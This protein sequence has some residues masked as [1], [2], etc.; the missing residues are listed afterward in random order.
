MKR[1]D[2]SIKLLTRFKAMNF[3][4]RLVTQDKTWIQHFEPESKIQSKQRKYW[5]STPEEIQA[6]MSVGKLM[7]Y[8]LRD[9]KGMKTINGQYYTSNIR[10]LKET[11]KLKRRGKPRRNVYLL[12]DN[13]S[14]HTAQ[15][16]SGLHSQLWPWITTPFPLLIRFS[17]MRLLPVF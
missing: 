11:I 12:Q 2:I 17:S 10:Q 4:C 1:A 8:I 16:C 3:Y 14:V 6:G 5:F 13:S 15:I 9:S 7:T